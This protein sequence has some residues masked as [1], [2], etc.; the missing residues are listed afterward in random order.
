MLRLPTLGLAVA[1]KD[2]FA[3]HATL[4]REV[5]LSDGHVD[6]PDLVRTLC[7]KFRQ[8]RFRGHPGFDDKS[9]ARLQGAR[10]A[11]QKRFH[12]RIFEKT[13]T[14]SKTIR[15]IVNRFAFNAPHIT[16]HK[17]NRVR[18]ACGSGRLIFT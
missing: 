4:V 1:L 13:K 6:V 9:R 2:V 12:V 8:N 5:L 16:E 14:V 3:I 18:T 15:A 17:L 7:F 11:V 10:D